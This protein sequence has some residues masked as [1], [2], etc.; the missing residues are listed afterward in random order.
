M[1]VKRTAKLG[2][3]T[4]GFDKYLIKVRGYNY[5]KLYLNKLKLSLLKPFEHWKHQILQ[6]LK[7]FLLNPLKPLQF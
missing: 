3:N 6:A 4:V 1:A 5:L 7:A 2:K